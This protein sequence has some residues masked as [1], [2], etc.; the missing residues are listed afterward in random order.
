MWRL[1]IVFH[2]AIAA[3]LMGALILAAM[4]VPSLQ[5]ELGKWIPLKS[6]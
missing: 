2:V 1:A 4:M 3:T 6:G 5:S